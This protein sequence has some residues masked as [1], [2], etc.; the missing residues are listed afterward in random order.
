MLR[1]KNNAHPVRFK[2]LYGL[3]LALQFLT[4]LPIRTAFPWTKETSKWSVLSYPA[5]GL[6]LG[7]LAGVQAHFLLQ[8]SVIPVLMTSF[9][10]F[11]FSII[12]TG[13]LHLDGWMDCSDA[14]FSYGDKEKRLQIM[15]DP[16]TGAFGVLSVLFLLSWRFLF[17][18]ETMKMAPKL[19][20][21]LF[22]LIPFFARIGMGGLLISAPLAREE[23][24]AFAIKQNI[25]TR[26]F[27]VYAAYLLLAGIGAW[28][29]GA[30]LLF[31]SLFCLGSA[32]FLISKTFFVR[33]FGGIT[34]DTLG[35]LSE[36]METWLWFGGW[37][38]LSFATG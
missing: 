1:M 22:L 31:I 3:G 32:V 21:L 4:A 11:C 12:M 17:I 9:Y 34:G 27:P 14:Y 16:R 7:G 6:L 20:W 19:V 26:A 33:Q 13:G 10:L 18:F 15:K 29:A 8:Q 38:L 5:V 23:G 2:A 24:M 28:A 35:A 30:L 25:S 37:L 36:G